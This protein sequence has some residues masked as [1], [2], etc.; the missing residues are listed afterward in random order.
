ME[1]VVNILNNFINVL[2]MFVS[3]PNKLELFC[4]ISAIIVAYI[5]FIAELVSSKD[6]SKIYKRIIIKKSGIIIQLIIVM[7]IFLLLWCS[8]KDTYV[9]NIVIS[10]FI[11]LHMIYFVYNFVLIIRILRSG[12]FYNKIRLSYIEKNTKKFNDYDIK[13]QQLIDKSYKKIKNSN[14]RNICY[15]K[16]YYDYNEDYIKI[17]SPSSGVLKGID[18]I[19][20]SKIDSLIND[21]NLSYADNK[22]TST[23]SKKENT[24]KIII[25]STDN[26]YVKKDDVIVYI[27][28][29][30][31]YLEKKFLSVYGKTC[32]EYIESMRLFKVEE[33]LLFTDFDLNYISQ[34]TGFSDCSHMIKSFRQSR[35]VTP[36]KFRSEKRAGQQTT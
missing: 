3:S 24:K 15:E 7:I 31:S 2:S 16:Y 36:K 4:G 19:N 14:Y 21:N 6:S 23:S 5:I 1:I 20:F 32:K 34:E 9:I 29:E 12:D 18:K 28:K 8:N 35:G 17:I 25:C 30:Y 11:F 26:E 27:P 10:L 22:V 33:F 13:K